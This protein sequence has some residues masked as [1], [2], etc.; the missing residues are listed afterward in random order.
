VR[1]LAVGVDE[2]NPAFLAPRPGDNNFAPIRARIR[3]LSPA[4]WR[5]RV[6]W[7]AAMPT[8]DA[9]PVLDRPDAGCLRA[10]P[11]CAPYRGLRDQLRALRVAQQAAPGRFE[12]VVVFVGTPAW[13]AGPPTGCGFE[14]PR[15]Q[16]PRPDALGG[17]RRLVRAVVEL[18]NTEGVALRW[19]SPWNE[20]NH[21]YS[22]SPQ[23]QSCV[24]DA[25]A[26]APAAY[27]PIARALQAELAAVPG[28]QRMVLGDLAGFLSPR[29]RGAGVAEFV[30]ALPKDVACA[31]P[32]WA[33]HAYVGEQDPTGPLLAAV[34]A[35]GCTQ[36]ARVWVTET[37]A[38]DPRLGGKR[39]TSP[40]ALVAE[41][42][43]LHDQLT[44]WAADPRVE[45]A[46][47]YTV[48]EDPLFPVGLVDASLTRVYTPVMADWSAW[49]GARDANAPAPDMPAACR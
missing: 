15:S 48:R 36:P 13:A 11:P 47:Q 10:V 31:S 33:Q 38:G 46:T 12:P 28:E 42:R 27:V 19:F 20:P 37:G 49:G 6:D 1:G 7:A 2:P 5:L 22:L 43:A 25:A 14:L 39:D 16:A 35:Q 32:V 18:G 9:A 17:Y 23:R 40:A 44:Q 26:L 34:D 3:A 24:Q 45:A 29:R 8:K 30:Q 41:C 4:L 21:P